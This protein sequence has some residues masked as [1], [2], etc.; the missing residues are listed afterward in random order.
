MLIYHHH[1]DLHLAV[2]E[3][4]ERTRAFVL[5]AAHGQRLG[6]VGAEVALAHEG[7]LDRRAELGGGGALGDV[8][9]GAG[10]QRLERKRRLVGS[11]QHHHPRAEL[12]LVDPPGRLEPADAGHH[13]IHEN[14]VGAKLTGELHPRLAVLGF[15]DDLNPLQFV[16]HA[17]QPDP[18][19]PV[20]V[21]QHQ[22]DH[23]CPLHRPSLCWTANL[24]QREG[25]KQRRRPVSASV[26]GNFQIAI[27]A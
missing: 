15:A 9:D 23:A 25:W 16:E 6:H 21:H 5:E 7:A 26:S 3:L 27:E 22:S 8:A 19:Q 4:I 17:P 18:E 10:P 11:A 12:E 2:G 1:H 24:R 14:D 20:I 13:Q